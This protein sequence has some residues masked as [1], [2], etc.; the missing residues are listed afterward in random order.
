MIPSARLPG[1]AITGGWALTTSLM[2]FV[3]GLFSSL[4]AVFSAVILTVY[5][6]ALDGVPLIVSVSASN[7]SPS[8]SPVAVSVMGSVPVTAIAC[9]YSSLT[10][11][12]GRLDV[13]MFGLTGLA[14]M[15]KFTVNSVTLDDAVAVTL[16]L[17]FPAVLGVPEMSPVLLNDNPE[18][19]ADD[20][21]HVT[22]PDAV[23]ES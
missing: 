13:V 4:V 12:L 22:L 5:V 15:V 11:A 8:G 18:G 9:E 10:V 16:T 1:L 17:K 2:F 21:R 19:R 6:P 20:A 3:V 7:V 23:T 14:F